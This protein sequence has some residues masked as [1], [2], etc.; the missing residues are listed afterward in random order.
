MALPEPQP[1][2][3]IRYNY[4]WAD[5]QAQGATEGSKVRPAAIIV[6]T[7]TDEGE[8]VVFA[9]AITHTRPADLSFGIELP[10]ATRKRLGL[11]DEPSW[12]ITTE[13]NRFVWPGPDLRPIPGSDPKAWA[14]GFLPASFFDRVK[15][16]IIEHRK[17]GTGRITSPA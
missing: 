11:D 5:E 3:V 16:S 7:R 4:L 6:A 12:V 14:Y 1:A 13:L 2:L 9:A 17:N 8:Q 10:E 15:A